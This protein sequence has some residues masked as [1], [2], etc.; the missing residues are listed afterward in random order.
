METL[1][2][3]SLA[4]S[5][6]LSVSFL[7]VN[8]QCLF[9]DHTSPVG[10]DTAQI[11]MR[12]WNLVSNMT[13]EEKCDYIGELTSFV[14]RPVERLG[15]P[16]LLMADGPQGIRNIRRT[17]TVSTLYPCGELSAATWDTTLVRKLGNALGQDAKSRGISFLLGPGVNI[18]RA[19][20]CGRNF[21]YFGED[22]FL[23]SEI[24]ANYILGVQE[25]GVIATIKHFA[26]NNQEW[27]RHCR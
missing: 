10:K 11:D 7:E 6:L 15:I 27:S 5:A 17:N 8:A 19:P 3:I 1:R 25:E 12:A 14:I 2:R 9:P 18:Y 13:L 4:I 24:A 23:T 20:F 26:A 21:E 16:Q 22:P